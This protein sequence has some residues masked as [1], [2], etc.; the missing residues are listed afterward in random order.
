MNYFF[1]VWLAMMFVIEETF[2][3]SQKEVILGSQRIRLKYY[4]AVLAFFPLFIQSAFR[5]DIGELFLA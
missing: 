2:H 3:V 1:F 4:F 5:G